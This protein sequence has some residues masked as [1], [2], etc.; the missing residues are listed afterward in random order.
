MEID[1]ETI[2]SVRVAHPWHGVSPTT[3]DPSVFTAYIETLQFDTIK[4]ELD[5][6]S[7][8]L[9]VDRPQQRSTLPPYPYGFFPRT[10]SGQRVADIAGVKKGD[11]APL[12]VFILSERVISSRGILADVRIIGGI[13][14]L[15]NDFADDKLI[16]VLTQDGAMGDIRDL[17][18]LPVELLDRI[19]HYLVSDDML[20]AVTVGEAYDV[21]MALKVFHAARNDYTDA[22]GGHQ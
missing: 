12:D 4:Y 20:D 6:T 13:P 3:R 7:G 22:F 15:E 16:G 5:Q 19:I 1:E 17:A 2:E 11:G 10:C 9:K 14:V 18:S 8:L 21:P